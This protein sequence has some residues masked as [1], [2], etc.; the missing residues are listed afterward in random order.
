MTADLRC[1]LC[2]GESLRV[3]EHGF[4]PYRVVWCPTCQLARVVPQPPASLLAQAYE[5]DYYRPWVGR[6]AAAR[7]ALWLRRLRHLRRLG[8]RG[9][10][11]D[12]GCGDGGFLAAA[13]RAGF[14]VQGTEFSAYAAT[15]I[16]R[17]LGLRVDAGELQE[18]PLPTAAFRTVTLWHSLEHTRDPLEVLHTAWRLLLPGGLLLVAVPNSQDLVFQAAYRLLRGRA[19]HLFSPADRE[20]HLFGFT[21]ASLRAILARAGFE[22]VRVGPDHGQVPAG[23]RLLDGLAALV[24]ACL[25]RPWWNALLATARKPEAGPEPGGG[26]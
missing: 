26:R 6:Q 16:R 21:A 12:V 25:R 4:P 3:L 5:E 13:R 22:G 19:P 10:L 24:S 8:A 20:L 11:L 18:L 23:K 9:P 14:D 17:E 15:Y 1:Y 7:E 2:Q